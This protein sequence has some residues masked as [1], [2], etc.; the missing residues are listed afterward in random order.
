MALK[1]RSPADIGGIL[2]QNLTILKPVYSINKFYISN[3]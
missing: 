1:S 2:D 3:Y